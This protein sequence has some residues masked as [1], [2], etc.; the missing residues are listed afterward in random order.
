MLARR[1]ALRLTAG[2]C[3][4]KW[5]PAPGP[6]VDSAAAALSGPPPGKPLLP[7]KPLNCPPCVPSVDAATPGGRKWLKR[8]PPWPGK[9]TLAGQVIA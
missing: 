3:C 1:A 2:C 5:K 4:W 8:P 9:R 7:P 6:N